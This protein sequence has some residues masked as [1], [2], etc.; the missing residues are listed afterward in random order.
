MNN[1]LSGFAASPFSRNAARCGKGDAASAAGRPLRGGCWR[2]L[3]QLH[4]AGAEQHTME[5]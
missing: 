2:G 4:G 1:P 5:N 3:R